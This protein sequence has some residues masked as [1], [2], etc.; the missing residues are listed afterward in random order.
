[1]N[2]TDSDAVHAC[3]LAHALEMLSVGVP[4]TAVSHLL[5]GCSRASFVQVAPAPPPLYFPANSSENA[6]YYSGAGGASP[7]TP[8]LLIS[9]LVAVLLAHAA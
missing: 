1:V 6:G 8:L 3:F 5:S 9:L 2:A 7:S 4:V